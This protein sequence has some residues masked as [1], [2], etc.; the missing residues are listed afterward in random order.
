VLSR[1]A[2]ASVFANPRVMVLPADYSEGL[3]LVGGRLGAFAAQRIALD[4]GSPHLYFF[5]PFA[6]SALASQPADDGARFPWNRSP[7]MIAAYLEGDVALRARWVDEFVLGSIRFTN[8]VAGFEMPPPATDQID[9]PF[10]GIVGTDEL[11]L[12]D[13]WFDA[14]GSR[15]GLR[16]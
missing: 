12:F 14:D 10:D 3:P 8:L 15:V 5:S 11:R 6:Q 1:N 4:T 2:A 16:D 13:V 7:S 9:V